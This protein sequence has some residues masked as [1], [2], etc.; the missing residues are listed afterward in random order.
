MEYRQLG[1]CGLRVPVLSLGTATF[2]GVGE[3]FKAL[4]ATEVPEAKRLV[5]VCLE[6][7]ANFFYTA[8]LYSSGRSEEV[9]GGAIKGRRE[10]VLV[11]TK[12]TLPVGTDPNDFGS[13]RHG[14]LRACEHS[15]RRLSTDYI[16][17]Y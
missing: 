9:R 4:G 15:L 1:G 14:S 12:A 8:N 3:F 16:D 17:V 2:G 5:D 6:A 10:E 11:A 7:G 13:S